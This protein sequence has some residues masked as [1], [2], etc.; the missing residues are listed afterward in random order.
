MT[1]IT[2]AL[3]RAYANSSTSRDVGL[4]SV[5]QVFEGGSTCVVDTEPSV[6]DLAGTHEFRPTEW[7]HNDLRE[8]LDY[9]WEQNRSNP[10]L[11][12]G[13]SKI[14]RASLRRRSRI[15]STIGVHLEEGS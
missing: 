7:N 10:M 8:V 6:L 4:V 14:Y 2:R 3:V 15:S 1:N 5:G 11:Q 9:T 12:E 13:Y